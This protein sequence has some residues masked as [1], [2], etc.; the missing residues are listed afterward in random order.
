MRSVGQSK[1]E[2][3]QHLQYI[4]PESAS[5]ADE[6]SGVPSAAALFRREMAR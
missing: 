4:L 5:R 1:T 6:R 3:W 2:L